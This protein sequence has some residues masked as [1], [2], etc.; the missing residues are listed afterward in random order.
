MNSYT[1]EWEDR[2]N[3]MS[4]RVIFSAAGD[5]DAWWFFRTLNEPGKVTR[6]VCTH[7]GMERVDREIEC[8]PYELGGGPVFDIED[9]EVTCLFCGER[10]ALSMVSECEGRAIVEEGQNVGWPE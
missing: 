10:H 7:E 5:K 4:G 6:M 2:E 8:Y 3:D 1:I 9:H